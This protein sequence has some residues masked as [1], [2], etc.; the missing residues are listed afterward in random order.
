MR[1][2]LLGPPGAGKGTQA[3]RVADHLG[4]P[5]VGSGDLFRDH[6][7]QET[8]LGQLA[9]SYMKK[10]VLVPDSITIRMVMEWISKEATGTGFLLDG[11]PRTL[12]QATV[13]DRRLGEGA[14]DRVLYVNVSQEELVR[15]LAGRVVC[16]NCNRTYHKIS[17]PPPGDEVC[18][19]CQGSLYQRA[20]DKPEA[21]EKRLEVFFTQTAPLVNYYSIAG[22]LREVDGE[23]SIKMVGQAF[24]E[25]LT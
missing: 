12:N 25:A 19:D 7:Q 20:D 17:N 18:A 15:R 1:I 22:V 10:G 11:F 13:L 23:Q 16:N 8:E 21:V 5:K 4:V 3:T 9:D 14:I 6:L 24:I 2:I